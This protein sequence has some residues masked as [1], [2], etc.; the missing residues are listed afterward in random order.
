MVVVGA[1]IS[2]LAAAYRIEQL[3][4][5]RG[6]GINLKLIEAARRSGGVIE[7]VHRNGLLM[8]LGPDSMITDKPWGR[9]LCEEV[10][11]GERLV[12]TSEGR[13]RSFIARK[14]RLIPVPEGFYLLAPARLG[15]LILSPLFSPLGKLRMA[16][17]PFIPA[18]TA[19]SSNGKDESLAQFVRR[20]L[21][22]EALERAA[23][24]MIGGIYT[25]DPERLSLQATMPRFQQ[26][27]REHGS[28]I[29]ALVAAA[30][31]PNAAEAEASGPRYGLFATLAGGMQELPQRLAERLPADTIVT[32]ERVDGLTRQEGG[33]WLLGCRSGSP[34]HAD[35][36][37]LALP[38]YAAATLVSG[39]SGR[40]CSQLEAI[41]YAS[42]ATVNLS[43]DADAIGHRLDG[44]GFVVPAIEGRTILACTFATRKFSG[45]APEGTVLVRAFVGGALFP[46]K[47]D[48]DD[49]TMIRA[50][51]QDLRDLLKL[52]AAPREVLV[53][54]HQSAMP[55]YQVGHLDRVATIENCVSELDGLELAGNFLGGPGIPDCIRMANEAAG[56]L[57]AHLW[58]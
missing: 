54:R 26:M 33:G 39:L 49:E 46:E 22:R 25:A 51:V 7:T 13:R 40:L 48:M 55:Q 11:L 9:E 42:T 17:E 31:R 47:L 41:E 53:T 19:E 24:P 21:G 37:C 32:G 35:A 23:Q 29:R 36:V 2:G 12:G 58:A 30:S 5:Q 28:V 18:R 43:F 27:E 3:A 8:E 16:M 10:G 15:P 45:R 50:V 52:K 14:N 38:A 34:Y 1:G 57:A 6:Y 44:F 4:R 20:R 56:R